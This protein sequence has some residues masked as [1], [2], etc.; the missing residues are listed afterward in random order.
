MEFIIWLVGAMA[1]AWCLLNPFKVIGFFAETFGP[2]KPKP[3][4][5]AKPIK[6][7]AEV[8]A[9]EHAEWLEKAWTILRSNCTEHI[10]HHQKWFTCINCGQDEPWEY[11]EGCECRYEELHT[12]A[13]TLPQRVLVLR[14]PNC[15]HHGKD[16]T[17]WPLSE[18]KGRVIYGRDEYGDRISKSIAYE[19]GSALQPKVRRL[20]FDIPEGTK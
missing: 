19:K 10:Y 17:S 6:T 11:K 12:F 20:R 18:R 8:H 15:R 5:P 16:Y 3:V 1:F 14:R 13:H 7:L 2:A 4:E 9:D